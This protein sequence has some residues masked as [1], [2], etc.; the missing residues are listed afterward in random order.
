MHTEISI[1]PDGTTGFMILQP[2]PSDCDLLITQSAFQTH[3]SIPL[4]SILGWTFPLIV[5]ACLR[6]GAGLVLYLTSNLGR[7]LCPCDC[8][9]DRPS[10]GT[11]SRNSS[12]TS[13]SSSILSRR[14]YHLKPCQHGA[15][16]GNGE[17]QNLN[18]YQTSRVQIELVLRE[19]AQKS[20]LI[21]MMW[22]W[23]H[24][25]ISLSRYSF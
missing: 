25:H 10:G 12:A 16:E 5:I 20:F 22:T 11:S 4:Y 3:R 13:P 21:D 8:D 18:V 2:W 23:A 7:D 1:N 17:L 14:P 6:T 24:F 19:G 15:A 9:R